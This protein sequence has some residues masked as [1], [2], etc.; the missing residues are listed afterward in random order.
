MQDRTFDS[1]SQEARPNS[2]NNGNP[3]SDPQRGTRRQADRNGRLVP[4]PRMAAPVLKFLRQTVD[5]CRTIECR[6]PVLSVT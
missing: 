6:T 5:Q 3:E 2:G 4:G 1:R